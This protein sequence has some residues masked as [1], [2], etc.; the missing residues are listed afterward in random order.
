M[1]A[2]QMKHEVL[3]LVNAGRCVRFTFTLANLIFFKD[4]CA[5]YTCSEERPDH[6]N[7]L[8]RIVSPCAQLVHTVVQVDFWNGSVGTSREG[9]KALYWKTHTRTTRRQRRGKGKR[10]RKLFDGA[11]Q[12]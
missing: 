5:K 3:P 9:P 11:P 4:K 8:K 2:F 1:T 7:L 10:E 12:L 6:N